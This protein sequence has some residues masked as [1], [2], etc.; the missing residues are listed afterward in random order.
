M[1]IET[2]API[3]LRLGKGLGHNN[4]SM[5]MSLYSLLKDQSIGPRELIGMLPNSQVK[6]NYLLIRTSRLFFSHVTILIFKNI[7]QNFSVQESR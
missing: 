1:S 4:E 6:S 7:N 2:K 5:K 3:G